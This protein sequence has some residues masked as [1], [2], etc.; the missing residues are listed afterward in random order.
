VNVHW[1]LLWARA[2]DEAE[3]E[4]W[5]RALRFEV[6]GTELLAPSAAD[7][8]VHICAHGARWT[9]RQRILWV[10][11]AALLMRTSAIDWA[12]FVAQTERLGLALPIAST[13]GY[14]RSVMRA[15]VPDAVMQTLKQSP[16]TS[17]ERRLYRSQLQSPEQ[18]GF[19][20]A[21]RL[22]HYIARHELVRSQGL[23]GYWHYFLAKRRGRSLLDV[24]SWVR[25]R[26]TRGASS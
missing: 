10:A 17:I 19:L 12:H 2:S 9:G 26:L 23:I 21:L 4:L 1:R 20:D 24:L 3:A 11:D 13:L 16:V 5:R 6:G 8:L 15:P 22:H 25:Q 14:L 7:I 18:R